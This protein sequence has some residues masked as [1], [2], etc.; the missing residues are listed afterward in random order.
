MHKTVISTSSKNSDPVTVLF[1]RTVRAGKEKEYQSWYKELIHLSEAS[2]GHISNHVIKQHR[3]YLTLQQFSDD[4]SLETWLKS[5]ERKSQ[6]GKLLELTEKAP[7]P[8]TLSGLEPWFELPNQ[9]A[10]HVPKWKMAL[11]TYCVIY[12]LIT[13][14]SY[15]LLPHIAG[16]PIPVRSAV[17]PLVM[18]PLM[19]FVI[20]PR[21]TKLLR[22][23]LYR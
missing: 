11:V 8:T 3:H 15:I 12:L 4:T 6:I 2:P 14:L 17:T 20:M 18:V 10:P 13:I 23:W 21:V 22:K 5:Y 9:A 19:T 1:D 7:E 16:W